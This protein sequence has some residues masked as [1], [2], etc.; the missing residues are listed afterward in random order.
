MLPVH[1]F[2]LNL[3]SGVRLSCFCPLRHLL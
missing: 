1:I 3:G 2:D